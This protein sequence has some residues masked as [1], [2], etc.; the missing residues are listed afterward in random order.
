[1]NKRTKEKRTLSWNKKLV[2]VNSVKELDEFL[3]K[4]TQETKDDLPFT[5]TLTYKDGSSL[6]IGLGRDGSAL[7]YISS[8]LDPPYYMSLGDSRRKEPIEFVFGN[9]MT[10]LPPWSTIPTENAREALRYFF[11]TGKLWSQI[12]WKEN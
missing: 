12:K 6:S 7:S 2:T 11:K 10:E 3:D 1:M 9:E 8:S 5:A 4:L